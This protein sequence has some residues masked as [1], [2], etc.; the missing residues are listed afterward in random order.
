MIPS[1]LVTWVVFSVV[2]LGA[3]NL[4]KHWHKNHH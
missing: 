1:I 2:T 3:Y 4:A